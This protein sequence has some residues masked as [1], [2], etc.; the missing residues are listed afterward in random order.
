MANDKK[1]LGPLT[2]FTGVSKEL[3]SIDSNIS[4]LSKTS[5]K[6]NQLLKSILDFLKLRVDK[7]TKKED[8]ISSS[9][10][11]PII[12]AFD[13]VVDLSKK[14][15]K[16]TTKV[17]E[18]SSKKSADDLKVITEASKKEKI[19]QAKFEENQRRRKSKF[20]ED[21]RHKKSVH[22]KRERDKEIKAKKFRDQEAQIIENSKPKKKEKV[23]SI[24]VKD[25]VKDAAVARKNAV[26]DER[27]AKERRSVS[28]ERG[29]EIVQGAI[30]RTKGR[31][32]EKKDNT[33]ASIKAV[34][35]EIKESIQRKK[36]AAKA[37]ANATAQVAKDSASVALYLK[38]LASPKPKSKPAAPTTS[39]S[40][41]KSTGKP[42]EK[43]PSEKSEDAKKSELKEKE[44]EQRR[45]DNEL[46]KERDAKRIESFNQRSEQ[47]KSKAAE[48]QKRQATHAATHENERN[49]QHL[50]IKAGVWFPHSTRS[51]ENQS[52]SDDSGS[53]WDFDRD[54]KN[55]AKT[56][57]ERAKERLER[58]KKAKAAR[59][60][61]RFGRVG[62][63]FSR[64][65]A[66]AS[67]VASDIGSV[68]R[69][70]SVASEVGT[71]GR[72]LSA[73]K[74]VLGT[75]GRAGGGLLAGAGLALAAGDI[76]SNFSKSSDSNLAED[77]RHKAKNAAVG[78]TAGAAIGGVLGLIGGPMGAMIGASLGETVGSTVGEY[79]DEIGKTL[80]S[81]SDYVESGVMKSITPLSNF[82]TS[83][84][85]SIADAANYVEKGVENNVIG[86]LT[87]VVKGVPEFINSA[88]NTLEKGISD[89]GPGIAHAM[90][91]AVLGPLALMNADNLSSLKDTFEKDIVPG[92]ESVFGPLSDFR[93]IFDGFEDT[94]KNWGSNLWQGAKNVGGGIANAAQQAGEGA[95]NLAHKAWSG[96]K[97]ALGISPE[98]VK[99]AN[100]AQ[101]KYGVPAAITLGQYGLESGGGKHMPAGSNNPFGIKANKDQIA[102]GQYVEAMTTEHVNGQDV[103]VPQKFAKYNSLDESFEAHAKL[104]A[105]GKAY[106]KARG[107]NSIEDYAKA[108]T[109]TYATDPNY[110]N[111]LLSVIS[112]QQ[113]AQTQLASSLGDSA[114][115]L[116][117]AQTDW[118]KTSSIA[119]K[120]GPTV[121]AAAKLP[122]MVA[123][124]KVA[125][126]PVTVASTTANQLQRS[127]EDYNSFPNVP[128]A[129]S[130]GIIPAVYNG[131]AVSAQKTSFSDIQETSLP[132]NS[133]ASPLAQTTLPVQVEIAEGTPFTSQ[134]PNVS[135]SPA[136][137]STSAMGNISSL[138]ITAQSVS[139]NG[140]NVT[141]QS[142][143]QGNTSYTDAS[144]NPVSQYNPS[145]SS[146]VP[147]IVGYAGAPLVQNRPANY[148]SG[149]S[150]GSMLGGLGLGSIGT[151]FNPSSGG[152]LNS[153]S[154]SL[155]GALNSAYMAPS[156]I[157][158]SIIN[159]PQNLGE[160][161]GG[162]GGA[163]VLGNIGQIG[164]LKSTLGNLGSTVSNFGSKLNSG[165]NAPLIRAGIGGA[166]LLFGGLSSL[167][168][169]DNASSNNQSPYGTVINSG[170]QAQNG[171]YSNQYGT[172]INSGGNP[173]V[174]AQPSSGF[175]L[176]SPSTWF[177]GNGS[178]ATN[179][180]P[181]SGYGGFGSQASLG[182][183]GGSGSGSI[184]G[185]ANAAMLA[186]GRIM[187]GVT[188]LEHN[189]SSAVSG[190]GGSNMLGN[191]GQ[192]GGISNALNG[193]APIVGTVGGLGT[194]LGS[195]FGLGNSNSGIG[196][197]YSTINRNP[198]SDYVN[199]QSFSAS[200][201][202]TTGG[203]ITEAMP[204][205]M[206]VERASYTP[207]SNEPPEIIMPEM[208][209]QAQPQAQPQ[210]QAPSRS[211]G[212]GHPGSVRPNIDDIPINI[213]DSGLMLLN[214]GYL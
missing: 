69:G 150:F 13:E 181:T 53:N 67:E 175:S 84:E 153:G 131:P 1:V 2:S 32:K 23:Q 29:K 170:G 31:I 174:S 12:S 120:G 110:D 21:E 166:G 98:A 97:S 24:K 146:G 82:A 87:T 207:I 177:G 96:V 191:I 130:L 4:K 75:V 6:H 149:P 46:R 72:I 61:S 51:K 83:A 74:S 141:N 168:S 208:P 43:A 159:L 145:Y 68:A 178:N 121:E 165:P 164:P 169:S 5:D 126:A 198:T 27:I 203:R 167:F 104:L 108:L 20:D 22:D 199:S 206:S 171:G 152:I 138:S 214:I 204:S 132:E 44:R 106:G 36:D 52:N 9:D 35:D 99:A 119:P 185:T 193:V 142:Q 19:E 197:S 57:R 190:G 136:S 118:S 103:R 117:S 55:K 183:Y 73:G 210:A 15:F 95:S 111:K 205:A 137:V 48:N 147:S 100:S 160:M 65:T 211:G 113:I 37:V 148:S 89:Y 163:N 184:I 45:A 140:Q 8:L 66:A 123:A 187:S 155:V 172:V 86:P 3:K 11:D 18:K 62:Q 176:F 79:S 78:G 109:G 102:S 112:R 105:N 143:G 107:A 63:L 180:M 34:Q 60:G 10:F 122:P 16:S 162:S 49:V 200:P 70:A 161:I 212:G 81:A 39:A 54:K 114:T 157:G 14:G 194:A 30:D 192:I 38:S 156:R 58:M 139:V 17:V 158:N 182:G 134:Q 33:A 40:E 93:K 25:T 186:P 124:Q 195:M 42:I 64:G 201:Q 189:M 116:D 213:N 154:G 151:L 26:I 59:G 94:I 76:Y 188:N 125:Y 71:G 28:K 101:E 128:N 56:K 41:A 88:A 127:T 85:H 202:S 133:V 209:Q 196:S 50:A 115:T 179:Y 77:E 80:K 90:E 47:A 129:N 92:I 135:A 173:N 144:G 7:G 91:Y